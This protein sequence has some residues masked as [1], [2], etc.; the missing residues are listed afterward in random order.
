MEMS[1]EIK[2]VVDS[3]NIISPFGGRS[4]H[5]QTL[6][7][8]KLC[9]SYQLKCGLDISK[10]LKNLNS[11]MIELYK[12]EKTGYKYWL[13]NDISY[14]E[15]F[16]REISSCWPGYYRVDRWEHEVSLRYLKNLD[17]ILEIGC[18]PGHFLKKME[19]F[20]KKAVGIEFNKEAID[21]KVTKFPIYSKD[22]NVLSNEEPCKYD[23]VYAFQVLEHV[24]NPSDIIESSIKCLRPGGLL[25]FSVPNNE[26]VHFLNQEDPFDLPPHH[27][28]H[29]TPLVFENIA[30]IYGLDI[31][32][33]HIE[34]RKAKS[35]DALKKTKSSIVHKAFSFLSKCLLNLSFL[36]NREPGPNLIVVFK[37]R[38]DS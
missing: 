19:R 7:T 16:Y 17:Y 24:K 6:S 38:H 26:Y 32:K 10:H 29:Y 28:G 21:R 18:G 22:I 8:A 30:K 35:I 20:G 13:P 33:V 12:C 5:L 23:A 27:L 3:E 14:S 11:S 1:P 31:L 37:K 9:A 15:T 34:I 4:T 36:M 2:P 25:I